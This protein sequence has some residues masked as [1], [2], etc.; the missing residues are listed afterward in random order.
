[1][2][3]LRHR[4]SVSLLNKPLSLSLSE[5][6]LAAAPAQICVVREKPSPTFRKAGKPLPL[7]SAKTRLQRD[8]KRDAKKNAAQLEHR[9]DIFSQ[10]PLILRSNW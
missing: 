2:S 9:D 10:L 5:P 6:R 3:C 8:P 1:M 4:C 7:P